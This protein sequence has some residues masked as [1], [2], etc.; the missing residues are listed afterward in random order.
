[1]TLIY[2]ILI[3]G[4]TVLIHE[5]GHYLMAKK[6]GVYVYEFSIGMGPR[7]FK[8]NRK[9]DETEYSIR[10]L[11][12]GGYVS[13]AG[14]EE[15]KNPKVPKG[16]QLQDKSFIQNILIMG[17]GVFNNFLLALFLL[18]IVGLFNGYTETKPIVST[19]VDDSPAYIAGIEVGD[20]ITSLNGHHINNTDKLLLEL[21]TISDEN[22][23][24]EIDRDGS[25]KQI[26]LNANRETDEDGNVSYKMGFTLDNTNSKGIG[27]AIKYAFTKFGSLVEQM[28][29]ILIYLF[30]GKLSVNNL[31][32]PVGI[33]VLVGSVAK[34]GLINLVYLMGYISLNVGIINILPFPAFDGGRIFLL[35]LEKIRGKK[36]SQK[37]ENSINTVGFILLM[38][39]MIYVTFNDILH[40]F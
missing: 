13:L 18:F 1:M 34:Q 24:L 31:S 39:L 33:Y 26:S 15:E 8:W 4:I 21:T 36:L 40:L 29:F 6:A 27:Y 19:V 20:R 2:F 12:I 17:A 14:E 10:I 11:P 25:K 16:R 30:S 37:I 22:I 23:T 32:G 9:N 3:L 7:L 5:F 28:V 38:L 35:I